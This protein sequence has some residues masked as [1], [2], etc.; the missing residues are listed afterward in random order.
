MIRAIN[1]GGDDQFANTAAPYL[2]LPLFMRFLAVQSFI[3]EWD[4]VLGYAG[5]NNFYLYRFE[6]S[7]RSQLI[8]WDED[9]A[10]RA[11]DYPILPGFEQNVLVRRGMDR[12]AVPPAVC[13]AD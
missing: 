1:R 9:N 2:D 4:G 3:A 8:P 12:P 11:L 5:A 6:N 13:G 10:F 7:I